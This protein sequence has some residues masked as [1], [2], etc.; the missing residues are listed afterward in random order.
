MCNC[1]R[2]GKTT[3]SPF[4]DQFVADPTTM[5]GLEWDEQPDEQ[6]AEDAI[7]K[8]RLWLADCCEHPNMNF[9]SEFIASWKG[10]QGF[11][12]ALEGLDR[13][14]FKTLLSQLPD[15]DDG[16]TT[17]DKARLMLAELDDFASAQAQVKHAVLVDDERDQIISMG[18]H[19]LQ[20]A[21][22]VD[23]NTG[24]DIGFNEQG[25]FVRDRWELN[26]VLFQSMHFEQRLLLPETS[27][28]E[29]VD[30]E[31]KRHLRCNT[32]FGKSII[33]ADGLP[34]MVFARMRVDL[35]AS[36]ENRFAYI[37]EPLRRVLNASLE[38]DN[39]V[40]WH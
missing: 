30:I 32:P 34:R 19:I 25:F 33:G 1:Y 36:T 7:A 21:L 12:D 35:I 20:G 13:V 38:T 22:A 28:V 18:S 9:A 29:Y 39:P 17:P 5:P 14:R 26:R 6:T 15:G 31:T 24:L 37:T 2:D 11:T 8:L 10:Y 27:Q 23:P 40:R 4:P 3:P 16:I